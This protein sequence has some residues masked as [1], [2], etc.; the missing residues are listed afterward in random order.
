MELHGLGL[1]LVFAIYKERTSFLGRGRQSCMHLGAFSTVHCACIV[2]FPSIV[3]GVNARPTQQVLRAALLA[4]AQTYAPYPPHD[5]RIT[6]ETYVNIVMINLLSF[7]TEFGGEV[8]QDSQCISG[9]STLVCAA[10]TLATSKSS[11]TQ[12]AEIL[13]VDYSCVGGKFVVSVH[14]GQEHERKRARRRRRVRSVR[15]RVRLR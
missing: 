5:E 10:A 12:Q 1:D 15:A 3:T 2:P 8:A 13:R 11:A 14:K 7:D 6:I 9:G 4:E